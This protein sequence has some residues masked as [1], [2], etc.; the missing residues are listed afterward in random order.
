M[1]IHPHCHIHGNIH[2]HIYI[3]IYININIYIYI[4]I[5][6]FGFLGFLKR[7][8]FRSASLLPVGSISLANGVI[9]DS[10]LIQRLPQTNKNRLH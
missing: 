9:A 8:F 2:I 10:V 7:G 4:Y 6:F 1:D 3:N 5:G